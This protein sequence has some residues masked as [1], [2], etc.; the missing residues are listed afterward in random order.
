LAKNRAE[1]LGQKLPADR[2]AHRGSFP[3]T[4][5]RIVGVYA[6]NAEHRLTHHGTKTHMHALLEDKEGQQYTGHIERVGLS[7]GTLLRLP[8]Q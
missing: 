6:E 7:A 8:A 2:Q 4:A 1:R 3:K 5:G